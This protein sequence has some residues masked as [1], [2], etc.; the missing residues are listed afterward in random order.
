MEGVASNPPHFPWSSSNTSSRTL[1]SMTSNTRCASVSFFNS[2]ISSFPILKLPS[3]RNWRQPTHSHLI[4]AILNL[5]NAG[6]RATVLRLGPSGDRPCNQ[7]LM[8]AAIALDCDSVTA[9][10]WVEDADWWFSATV[11]GARFSSYVRECISAL[12][13]VLGSRM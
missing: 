9:K 3:S 6:K 8:K 5:P 4:S 10:F 7:P 2:F 13:A 12:L 11:G 1:W